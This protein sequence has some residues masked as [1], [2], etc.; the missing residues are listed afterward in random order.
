M[1]PGRTISTI[2]IAPAMTNAIRSGVNLS[3]RNTRAIKTTI[4]GV[5]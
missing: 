3:P 5:E 1:L 2:P 4:I